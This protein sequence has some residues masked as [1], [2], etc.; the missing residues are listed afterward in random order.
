MATAVPFMQ[1]GTIPHAMAITVREFRFAS[2]AE[3]GCT[4]LD[5]RAFEVV[6][7]AMNPDAPEVG[8]AKIIPPINN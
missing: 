3:L 2:L 8:F 7:G 1:H 5:A 6:A 4:A